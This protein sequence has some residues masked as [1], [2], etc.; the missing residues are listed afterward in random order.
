MPLC[1]V[2]RASTVSKL[3]VNKKAFVKWLVWD[4]LLI[5][6]LALNLVVG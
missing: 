4:L 5:L 3:T 6:L 2:R 1:T